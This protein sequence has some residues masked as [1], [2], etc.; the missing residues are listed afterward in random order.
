MGNKKRNWLDRLK[1]LVRDAEAEAEKEKEEEEVK[2]EFP[3]KEDEEK[4]EKEKATDADIFESRLARIEAVINK[5][6]P[7]EEAEHG[8][9]LDGEC[10]EE[11]EKEEETVDTILEPET[12]P[13]A[14][15]GTVL[16]GDSLKE[17]ICLAEILAPGISIPTGDAAKDKK[18]IPR[19][20][21]KAIQVAMTTDAGKEAV[22]V[23]LGK[24]EL[25]KLTFDQLSMVFNGASKLMRAKNNTDLGTLTARVKDFGKA[26]PVEQ[27]NA[28]NREFWAQR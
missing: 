12:T 4:E 5:L 2:D 14:D 20:Q 23:F 22:N 11:G 3:E 17:V 19:L 1:A 26:T 7:L 15:T 27:I 24:N 6:I 25:R 16:M 18:A 21:A 28:K 9:Q 13:K 8:Q 10:E